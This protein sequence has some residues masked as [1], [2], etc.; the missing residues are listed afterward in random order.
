MSKPSII[1]VPGAATLP[2]FYDNVTLPVA[3]AGYEI[4]TLHL[5]S[6]GLRGGEGR[7]SPPGT[8]YED[9]A[10]IA[11]EVS[12]LADQGKDVVIFAHSYGGIPSSQST[13]GLS[14]KERQEQGKPGGVVQLAYLTAL[15]PALGATGMEISGSF[16]DERNQATFLPDVGLLFC[17]VYAVH[18]PRLTHLYR[19]TAGCS[20]RISARP[21][22]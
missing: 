16:R 5:G 12:A 2:E 17:V 4:K 6:A 14:K 19:K 11:N 3:A 15:V 21:P 22:R 9:A 8:M 18:G 13:K 20:W 1:L 7:D 10:L